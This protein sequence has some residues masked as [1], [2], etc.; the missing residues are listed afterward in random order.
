M[1][2]VSILTV[3]ISMLCSRAPA[4]CS[5]W[6]SQAA[7]GAIVCSGLCPGVLRLC[8]AAAAAAAAAACAMVCPGCKFGRHDALQ[9]VPTVCHTSCLIPLSFHSLR[10]LYECS[11]PTH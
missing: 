1:S 9:L 2:T 11:T 8:R 6:C 10:S 5:P 4:V 3:R 7:G